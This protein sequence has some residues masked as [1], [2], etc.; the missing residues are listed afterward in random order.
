M[1]VS[2]KYDD[3][4]NMPHHVSQKRRHMLRLN[5]AAQFASFA[6]LSGYE[7]AI[8]ETARR[9][10]CKAELC[11]DDAAELDEKIKLLS[12]KISEEPYCEVTYFVPDRLKSGGKYITVSGNLRLIEEMPR[13]LVFCGGMRIPLDGVVKI[14]V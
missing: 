5:R 11:E 9:T 8:D 13:Q 4:I 14:S 7:D 12:D 3:I 10:D 2:D 6:A 1:S